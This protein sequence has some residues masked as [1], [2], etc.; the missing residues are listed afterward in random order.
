MIAY[1]L[2]ACANLFIPRLPPEHPGAD[3]HPWQLIAKF[4]A[5]LLLMFRD[6]D[7]R[8]S[9]LGTSMFWGSG[10]TLRLML[11]A[12]VPAALLIPDNQTPANLMGAVSIGV[13]L[14]AG[15]AG[16][17]VTLSKV[18]RALI[19]GCCWD[20]RS[21]RL[22]SYTASRPPQWSWLRSAPAADCSSSRSMPC[23]NSAGTPR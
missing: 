4:G 7:A 3:F 15:G 1:A 20:L 6:R 14:G 18:N 5:A 22:A 13:V 10:I 23:C 16:L 9:L 2:A 17:W 21:S 8:F 11:F 12:W 19:G